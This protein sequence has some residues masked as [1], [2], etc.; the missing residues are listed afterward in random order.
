MFKRILNF[1]REPRVQGI[2]P[3]SDELLVV[4]RK[5]LMEKPMMKQVFSEFYSTCI[6]LDEK[7]FSGSGKRVEIGAGVS[8][9][10]QQ[11]PEIVS[12][13]IKRAENLDMVLDAQNMALEDNSVRAIYGINCFHHFP[14]PEKFFHE[15]ERVLVKGGGCILIEPYYGA[16]AKRFYKR[17]FETECFEPDQKEWTNY[18][19]GVMKGANQALSYIV[20]I[21]DR[22]EFERLHPQLEIVLQRPLANYVRYLCSGGLNFRQLLP[23]FFS[24]VLK[25][26]EFLLTPLHRVLGLHH[27]IVIRK[28]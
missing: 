5:V 11:H 9:F 26:V 20:F 27:V 14:E 7:Y 15:L 18:S 23:G 4:H 10:K 16:V 24:P 19:A 22:K 21:R 12:T 1:L 28:R 13:D 6:T 3:D 2:D 17:L 25:G 8:F